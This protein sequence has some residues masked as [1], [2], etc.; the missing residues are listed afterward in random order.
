MAEIIRGTDVTQNPKADIFYD[1]TRYE[2]EGGITD[3]IFFDQ[4]TGVSET[5]PQQYKFEERIGA[6]GQKYY[7]RVAID[8]TGSLRVDL[9]KHAGIAISEKRGAPG[10]IYYTKPRVL[11]I[12]SLPERPQNLSTKVNPLKILQNGLPAIDLQGIGEGENKRIDLVFND[13]EAKKAYN[14]M[15]RRG[16]KQRESV[17]QDWLKMT[18]VQRNISQIAVEAIH[19]ELMEKVKPA[20][21]IAK[22][23]NIIDLELERIDMSEGKNLERPSELWIGIDTEKKDED[24]GYKIG[25]DDGKIVINDRDMRETYKAMNLRYKAEGKVD[26]LNKI[27]QY[28]KRVFLRRYINDNPH[29]FTDE[30]TVE[31]LWKKMDAIYGQSEK[32]YGDAFSAEDLQKLVEEGMANGSDLIFGV[33]GHPEWLKVAERPVWSDEMLSRR[34]KRLTKGLERLMMKT[35]ERIGIESTTILTTI[36]LQGVGKGSLNESLNTLAETFSPEKKQYS[37]TIQIFLDESD[38]SKC[39][40]I[41]TGTGQRGGIF[42][43]KWHKEPNPRYV[44]H[45]NLKSSAGIPLRRG[46]LLNDNTMNDIGDFEILK[47]MTSRGR[48]GEKVIIIGETFPRSVG[49]VEYMRHLKQEFK[50]R[51]LEFNSRMIHLELVDEEGA[52]LLEGNRDL[53]AKVSA[54]LGSLLERYSKDDNV[55][56][57]DIYAKLGLKKGQPLTDE[58]VKDIKSG[59]T[60]MLAG[61][62]GQMAAFLAGSKLDITEI[63]P[64]EVEIAETIFDTLKA[65]VGTSIGR[66]ALRFGKQMRDDESNA[67][68]LTRRF[69]EHYKNSMPA[70]LLSNAEIV[71]GGVAPEKAIEYMMKA[72]IKQINP[73]YDFSSEEFITLLNKGVEIHKETVYG[74][75]A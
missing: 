29:E 66:I 41:E 11:E 59:G 55:K 2:Q 32:P 45:S 31:N 16:S 1:V 37:K 40:L 28:L 65:G 43:S 74:K 61:F 64:D 44:V 5:F 33:D 25:I 68:S 39:D 72:K 75:V 69:A 21:T 73:D 14:D 47:S 48:K 36:G 57:L 34:S 62:G 6:D 42:N 30:P 54:Q 49:Q 9:I 4:V 7:E 58:M 35:Q 17:V 38:L 52:K 18:I 56:G 10:E 26:E 13:P 46:F 22:L 67:S 27:E 20:E 23:E 50:E 3:F 53:S 12:D 51:G 60:E 71:P 24:G 63:D 70:A 19:N 15:V 8:R